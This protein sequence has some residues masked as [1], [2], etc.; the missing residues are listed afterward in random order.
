MAHQELHDFI[1]LCIG[2]DGDARPE[3]RQLLKHPFF[4][5]IRAGKAERPAALLESG[6]QSEELMAAEQPSRPPSSCGTEG[7]GGGD[8]PSPKSH[9]T[10]LINLAE[11]EQLSAEEAEG[12]EEGGA[13]PRGAK[14][15]AAAA[16]RRSDPSDRGGASG[17]GGGGG[18]PLSPN[19]A[20][21]AAAAG[22]HVTWA[23]VAR[24]RFSIADEEP[25]A[26]DQPAGAWAGG[27]EGGYAD[28]Y[29]GGQLAEDED[30][31][32]GELA[33]EGSRDL[34]VACQQAEENKLSF[35][36]RF[37]EPEGG[38]GWGLRAGAIHAQCMLCAV[39]WS[40]AKYAPCCPATLPTPTHPRAPPPRPLQ[41]RRVHV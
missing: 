25:E 36:L 12:E 7:D 3:A 11:M 4:D 13:A 10:Q 5:S 1:K 22:G 6:R 33:E 18:P 28:E 2:H 20:A 14:E 29:E 41:D 24:G 34:S 37:T 8:S 31:D 19:S 17:S 26:A 9:A 39:G 32:G 15:G 23:D 16:A 27:G 38:L 21:A 40:Q 35:Q 30:E